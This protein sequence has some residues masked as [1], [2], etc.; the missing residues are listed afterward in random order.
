MPV[1]FSNL[2]SGSGTAA[3]STATSSITLT[4][5]RLALISVSTSCNATPANAPTCSGWT[6]VSTLLFKD[7]G[8]DRCRVTVLRRLAGSDSTGTLTI[9]FASQNQDQIRYSIDQSDA[10]VDTTG[11]NG[12]GAIVQSVTASGLSTSPAATLAAFSSADNGTFGAMGAAYGPGN[13]TVGSG[14]TQLAEVVFGNFDATSV[15]TEY[16]IDN[17]TTVDASIAN[18]TE[19]GV[20]ALEIKAAGTVVLM[21]QSCC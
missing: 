7:S 14:F 5:N 9:D 13:A 17:D 11:T 8:G 19:W 18:S 21:G 2:T 15:Y 1:A 4:A 12:S 3:S 16:R 6:Q 10:A 20:V